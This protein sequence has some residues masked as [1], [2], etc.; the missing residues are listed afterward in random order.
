MTTQTQFMALKEAGYNL[1][2]VYRQRLADTE[3]P[4][5]VFA[6]L[7]EHKQAYLFESVEGGENW[8]RFSI[9]G[10]GESTVFSCNAGILTIQ[11]ADGTIEKQICSDP[12]E[13]IRAFQSQ[14]KVP[15]KEDLPAL[16]SFT[17][18]LVGYLG[19]DAVRY[20]EPKLKNVP[21]AD[22]VGLPDIWLMLSKTVIVFDNL[23]DTLFIIVHADVNQPDAYEN[24]QAQLNELEQLLATPVSL[25][26]KKHTPPQFVSLTGKEKF[27]ASIE[28]VKEYIRAGDVMQV[29]PG[30]RM[31][32]DFDG[33]PLQV[34]RA[35]RHLNP[36]PYLFLVQG[37]TLENNEPFHIVG[38][39]PEILSRLENGIATVRPLAG[40]RPRGKTKE[41]DLALEKDLLSDEK[42][43]AEH[44]MLIDLGRNDVGRVSKIGKVQ[45]TDQMVIE[46]YSHV[47]H[48]V[49]NVQ[50]EVRDDVDAL[51]VFKATFPAG[52]LS[53]APKIRAME[54]I[55]EV[56]PVKRGI[57]GGAVGYLG[58]HG[59]MDM[60]I[61]IR[62]CVI[63]RNKVF[64]Q[65]GAGL[66]ADSNPESEWNET[67]IKARA[68]I[69][70]VELSS[71]G[72]VL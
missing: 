9:I 7:K 30:H 46:R 58:W 37:Q 42:E 32:S 41:E 62:T 25:K 60:S 6:R 31:V 48:I 39:S 21:E 40:T 16:P 24:A 18:G 53:G 33:E 68:V 27:L 20:I 29:V 72:L 8:A 70:A 2:P 49:S 43:I 69:K 10:L 35:L 4:L 57:F 28:T 50:G 64:V 71:N 51:D 14:F 17:G 52:T 12:F 66:V 59:E 23:K 54:I 55:D 5:S 36:S 13:Y 26:E 38:S 15:T 22:P 1:I 63:R 56:E 65:A 19:Y 67:Q 34:Y 47:M 61:A 45:V 11:Q 3:T 44:L